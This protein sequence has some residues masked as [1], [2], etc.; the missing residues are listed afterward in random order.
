MVYLHILR[1]REVLDAE[2]FL[3]LGDTFVCKRYLLVLFL[4]RKVRILARLESSYEAVR[5][6]VHVCGVISLSGNNQRGSRFIYKYRVDLVDDGVVEFS[7]HHRFLVYDHIVSQVVEA[8]FVVCT[9]CDVRL[10]CSAPFR[11][12]NAVHNAAYRKSEEGIKLAHPFH[13]TLCEVVVDSDHVDALAFKSIEICRQ[14][15]HQSFTFTGLHLRYPSLV[16]HYSAY[17]LHVEVLHSQASPGT[18]S[19]DCKCLRK[20][21]VKSLT[22]FYPFLEFLSLLTKLIVCQ[23]LHLLIILH[24]LIR[25]LRNLFN[26]LFVKVSKDFFH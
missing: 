23:A 18:F 7:L 22:V 13:I 24:Y 19:A 20:Y 5:T 8:V 17:Y 4:Y 9:V 3:T 1:I 21:I 25:Y 16:K 6:F 12:R 15:C 14:R 2:V 10:I 11:L 26:F